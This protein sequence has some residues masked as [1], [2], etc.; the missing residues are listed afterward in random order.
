MVDLAC[1]RA[2][3][4]HSNQGVVPGSP[5][6]N[7][8]LE[9][10][11]LYHRGVPSYRNSRSGAAS[12]FRAL[13]HRFTLRIR[14]QQ[15]CDSAPHRRKFPFAAT[16]QLDNKSR[17]RAELS[18]PACGFDISIIQVMLLC[19]GGIV[20]YTLESIGRRPSPLP[21]CENTHVASVSRPLVNR[22]ARIHAGLHSSL[23]P[24][25][26]AGSSS[27]AAQRLASVI[28]V[29]RVRLRRRFREK[30]DGVSTYSRLHSDSP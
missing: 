12:L 29:T 22:C 8:A 11:A 30:L 24:R 25:G 18:G 17:E 19:F 27:L 7:V 20:R 6:R 26:P 10:G 3:M 14:F 15:K 13:R 4:G 16:E 5:G 21:L 23:T 2:L 1:N 9:Q 28:A